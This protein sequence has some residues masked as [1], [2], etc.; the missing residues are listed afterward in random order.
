MESHALHGARAKL[1]DFYSAPLAGFESAVDS[2][3]KMQMLEVQ[4]QR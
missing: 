2:H 4:G 1:A 3:V